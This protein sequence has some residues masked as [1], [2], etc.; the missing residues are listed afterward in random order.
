[1][2]NSV[3]TIVILHETL[4]S[5]LNLSYFVRWSRKGKD[6][7]L[8][9]F[10]DKNS[11]SCFAQLQVGRIRI[12]DPV[13][14]FLKVSQK[15][16]VVYTEIVSLLFAMFDNTWNLYLKQSTKKLKSSKLNSS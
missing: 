15:F 2:K 13:F 16:L 9:L 4:F 11:S 7:Q 6:L 10:S 12:S 14:V 3:K 1:M 5:N 8:K